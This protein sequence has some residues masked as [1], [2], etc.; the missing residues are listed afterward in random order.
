MARLE[1]KVVI[2][3][4]AAGGIGRAIAEEAG[5]E[6]ARL[7]LVDSDED[8]LVATAAAIQSNGAEVL[9]CAIDITKGLIRRIGIHEQVRSH[10]HRHSPAEQRCPIRRLVD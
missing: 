6:G 5:R 2:V 4:G 1:N 8:S 7:A 3:T 9:T 10:V